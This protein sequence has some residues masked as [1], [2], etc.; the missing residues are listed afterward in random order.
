MLHDEIEFEEL[1]AASE[2]QQASH[3]QSQQLQQELGGQHQGQQAVQQ[4]QQRQ[5]VYCYPC[6]CG[7]QYILTD[8]DLAVADEQIIIPCR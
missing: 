3:Q 8:S 4:N 5:L 1:E 7:D 6:R 2:G